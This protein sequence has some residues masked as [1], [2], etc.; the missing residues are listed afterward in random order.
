MIGL[1]CGADH[2]SRFRNYIYDV[3]KSAHSRRKYILIE[4]QRPAGERVCPSMQSGGPQI[5]VLIVDDRQAF[6]GFVRVVAAGCGYEARI[7]HFQDTFESV[8]SDWKPD[9]IVLDIIMPD[10]DGLEL[11]GALAKADYRGQLVLVSGAEELYLNMAAKSARDRGLAL[12]ATLAKPCR[13]EE[14]KQAL[15]KAAASILKKTGE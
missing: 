14:L 10:R 4:F 7:F 12:G 11:I 2:G 15:R 8:V 13:A 3:S 6:A 1:V 5:R 9:I